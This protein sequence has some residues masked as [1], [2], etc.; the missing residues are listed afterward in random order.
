MSNEHLKCAC[1]NTCI[2]T[3]LKKT[4]HVHFCMYTCKHAHFVHSIFTCIHLNLCVMGL[5]AIIFCVKQCVVSHVSRLFQRGTLTCD[6]SQ[7]LWKYM[8]K[9]FQ[10]RFQEILLETKPNLMQK[11]V[12]NSTS[13]PF[14]LDPDRPQTW[15]SPEQQQRQA[16]REPQST[17]IPW[18]G[19]TVMGIRSDNWR[20]GQLLHRGA[21]EEKKR[22]I[23]ETS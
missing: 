17:F 22:W 15:T 4:S 9:L 12:N 10:S 21:H 11:M 2:C 8:P 18:H 13:W 16:N 20:F 5:Y 3:H 6:S 1:T 19:K 14:S 7:I 23:L